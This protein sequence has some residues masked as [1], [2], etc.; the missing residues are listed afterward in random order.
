MLDWGDQF[1]VCCRTFSDPESVCGIKKPGQKSLALMLDKNGLLKR[2]GF[3]FV[4]VCGLIQCKIIV[5]KS[6]LYLA[7]SAV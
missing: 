6:F 3:V 5:C 4:L 1:F 2:G 7:G